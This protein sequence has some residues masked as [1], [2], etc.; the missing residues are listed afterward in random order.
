MSSAPSFESRAPMHEMH[1]P[2]AR[3][4]GIRIE[5]DAA[6]RPQGR[7]RVGPEHHNPAGVAHGG[8]VFALADTV[9][10]AAVHLRDNP[11][12][13]VFLATDVHVRYLRPVIEGELHATA[14]LEAAT[15]NTRVLSARVVREGDGAVV[16]L[17]TSRYQRLQAP[18]AG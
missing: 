16:A 1:H 10:G 8:L 15:R 13:A 6:G 12:R 4:L 14:Q 9:M 5:V 3:L 7:V 2:F 17:L 18:P 11:E